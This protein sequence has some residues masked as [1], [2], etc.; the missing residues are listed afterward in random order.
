MDWWEALLKY[1]TGLPQFDPDLDHTTGYAGVPPVQMSS[2]QNPRHTRDYLEG[3]YPAEFWAFPGKD[4][5]EHHGAS[6]ARADE[7][8]R[9]LDVGVRSW[10]PVGTDKKVGRMA[11][12]DEMPDKKNIVVRHR[13]VSEHPRFKQDQAKRERQAAI[14]RK[15]REE[16]RRRRYGIRKEAK[17]PAALEHKREYET[18]YESSPERKRYRRDLERERRKRG[19]AGKGGK[20]MSHTKRGNIVPEDPH[21]NRARSHPSVGST[22]KSDEYFD[23]QD[24]AETHPALT[25]PLAYDEEGQSLPRH[26]FLT[27]RLMMD[28]G[29]PCPHC[30][31]G[32]KLF[33]SE[34]A[35]GCTNE[36]CFMNTPDALQNSYEMH[37]EEM[38]KPPTQVVGQVNDPTDP[39]VMPEATKIDWGGLAPNEY[40]I[41]MPR[42]TPI[43]ADNK[44]SMDRTGYFT[45]GN[46]MDL[47]WRMLK[48]QTKLF[49]EGQRTLDGKPAFLPTDFAAMEERRRKAEAEAEAKEA[50]RQKMIENARKAG[51][52]TPLH[53]FAA[54]TPAPEDSRQP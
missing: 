15:R 19:V 31:G 1:Q 41:D 27:Q 14:E 40:H 8:G 26:D 53:G 30:E 3:R 11:T 39:R 7:H 47:S 12:P 18:R 42:S 48:E 6:R 34:G 23:P 37:S 44:P 38:A 21:T 35:V 16:R 28:T 46:P 33:T 25:H 49:Q 24:I 29:G 45:A 10:E 13:D 54:Q 52:T 20:D 43:Y 50:R 5:S 17:S 36:E 22:L 2:A 9:F 51:M 4:A 32:K